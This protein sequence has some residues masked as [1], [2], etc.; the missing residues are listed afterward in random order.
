MTPDLGSYFV[1]LLADGARPFR[2]RRRVPALLGL[3]DHNGSVFV[4]DRI[5]DVPTF[6]GL[7]PCE[8]YDPAI[9]RPDAAPCHPHERPGE[10]QPRGFGPSQPSDRERPYEQPRDGNS[11]STPVRRRGGHPGERPGSV[12]DPVI[13][14]DPFDAPE[15]VGEP[16]TADNTDSIPTRGGSGLGKTPPAAHTSTEPTVNHIV[17]PGTTTRP[18]ADTHRQTPARF[19]NIAPPPQRE[20]TTADPQRI[21]ELTTRP[22]M[23]GQTLGSR[24][25]SPPCTDTSPVAGSRPSAH[26]T[27]PSVEASAAAMPKPAPAPSTA[28]DQFTPSDRPS[29]KPLTPPSRATTKRDALDDASGAAQ[30]SA[31]STVPH[32]PTTDAGTAPTSHGTRE[33]R[34]PKRS[35]DAALKRSTAAAH[36]STSLPRSS[37]RATSADHLA[38]A[39]FSAAE[40]L[41]SDHRFSRAPHVPVSAA[42]VTL[43]HREQEQKHRPS[44]RCR[45]N[46]VP[47]GMPGAPEPE[48]SVL[49]EWPPSVIALDDTPPSDRP[50][51]STPASE[52]RATRTPAPEG[53]AAF[54]ER[55]HINRFRF[56]ILR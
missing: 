45:E 17:L 10:T 42:T 43:L 21:S 2:Y 22:S 29:A 14:A 1:T 30:R 38:D 7:R 56:G 19:G 23:Q 32:T 55:R 20:L 4:A 3:P 37:D 24:P 13:D 9:T 52:G 46:P 15:A 35:G 6:A 36:T 8:P 26:D 25:L 31:A 33:P 40:T 5:P 49:G 18:R 12:A 53:T 47:L 11:R 28:P 48:Q 50:V 27:P 39:T 54:W 44:R 16:G 34:L 41:T 51:P